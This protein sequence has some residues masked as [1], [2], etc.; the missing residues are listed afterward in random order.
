MS[1]LTLPACSR[2]LPTILFAAILFCGLGLRISWM[3]KSALWCDEAESSINAL[4]VLKTGLPVWTY[5]GLPI[6]ENTLTEPWEENPEYEFRDST[7]SHKGVVVYH[8]WLPIY[9]IAASQF[10]FGMRP[11]PLVSPPRVLHP[12][13][14]ID[15]RTFVPRVPA[16]V[17]SIL[18]MLVLYR[19]G[20][21]L[22]GRVAGFCALTLLAFN[23]QSVD[24]GIQARYYSLTLLMNAVSAWCLL[25]VIRRGGLSD[26]LL[27]GLAAATLFHTHLFSTI[28][29]TALAATLS[30]AII[31]QPGWF[32]KALA[33]ASLAGALVLPWIVLTGFLQTASSV[34]KVYQLFDS[35]REGVIYMIERPVPMVFLSILLGL[36][37]V[38]KGRPHWLPSR[39]AGNFAGHAL[40][41]MAL[42]FWMIITY[43]GFHLLMPAAS[44]FL[45]RLTLVLWIPYALILSLF[46]SDI[47]R[48]MPK[49][50]AILLG[51]AAMI[52]F[53]MVRGRFAFFEETWISSQKQAIAA[54]TNALSERT[55]EEGTR[56]YATPNEH[57]TIT[58]YT[59]LP[60]QSVAPV[61][62]SF[63]ESYPDPVVFIELQLDGIFP[64]KERVV[65]LA[66]SRGWPPTEEVLLKLSLPVWSGIITEQLAKRGIATE[67]L[68]TQDAMFDN[69]IR[70]T[71]PRFE[72]Q[73][74]E[75]IADMRANP[76]FRA[77]PAGTVNDLWLGFFYRFVDP[78]N[79]IGPNLNI[80]PRLRTANIELVPL[81]KAVIFTS[82][83][84]PRSGQDIGE[85]IK[86]R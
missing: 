58:Y 54:L 11:D 8:G 83:E 72:K 12:A 47:L 26:F 22:G 16:V 34:P 38:A 40:I 19:L 39:L 29:F 84:P 65:A 28:V 73:R 69:L 32:P 14:E 42:L 2:L 13:S 67:K 82:P 35:A 85:M 60:V 64:E 25:K 33:G 24:F 10:L 62:R 76:L 27:L 31:R 46:V 68:A 80:L 78:E 61:R 57:L 66:E 56:I 49:N 52:V 18:C 50:R 5:L 55:F 23:A 70:E 74:L 20:C 21:E 3:N 43:V 53:L 63:F 48:G 36:L 45:E 30:P 51:V 86:S 79:R 41:Y 6:Y 9:S 4:S 7:Y 77:V 1:A 15:F 81:A 37:V 75:W 71:I 59:G 17:F 44:Y